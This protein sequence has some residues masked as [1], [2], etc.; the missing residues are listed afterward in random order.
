[1]NSIDNAQERRVFQRFSTRFPTKFKDSHNDFGSDV[2]LRD[3]SASGACIVSRERFFLHDKISIEVKLPDRTEP[4]TIDGEVVW[5][6]LLDSSMWEI[7]LQ[8][9]QVRLMKMHRLLR[10]ALLES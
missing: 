3:A 9:A 7:G 5:Q 4:L 10:Y 1:M 2:F 8:F 6:K